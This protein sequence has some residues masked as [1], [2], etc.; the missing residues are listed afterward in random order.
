VSLESASSASTVPAAV[1]F[2]TTE[3]EELLENAGRE[4]VGVVPPEDPEPLEAPPDAEE[5]PPPPPPQ[6]P[7]SK[8]K[9]EKKT[10][11]DINYLP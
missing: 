7:S 2:S 8:T 6:D 5:P 10:I 1:L 11:R 3:K 4:L 9:T